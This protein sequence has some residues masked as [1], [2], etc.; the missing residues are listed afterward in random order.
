[1]KRFFG[2][3]LLSAL[4]GLAFCCAHPRTV[5]VADLHLGDPRSYLHD[6]EGLDWFVASVD[7][8]A[9]ETGGRVRELVI[10]GDA[11]ELLIADPDDAYARMADLLEALQGVRSLRRVVIVLGNHDRAVFRRVPDPAHHYNVP[12][13]G[14]TE[15]HQR[16]SPAAGRLE[17][18]LVYPA[19]EIQCHDTA[20]HITHGHYFDP[21]QTPA[22]EDVSSIAE[23]EDRNEAW[24]RAMEAGGDHEELRGLMRNAYHLGQH[25]SGLF[26]NVGALLDPDRRPTSPEID[27]QERARIAHY[28]NDVRG[29]TDDIVLVFGH[30]HTGAP[31]ATRVDPDP[32][33][34]R[35][36]VVVYN[37]G[38]WVTN[39][40]GG[41]TAT[42]VWVLDTAHGS[43]QT[44]TI[45]IP[46]E[47]DSRA[48]KR[49]Y[50]DALSPPS[51]ALP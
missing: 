44:V 42:Y 41:H 27:R 43:A 8:A 25:V 3:G 32:D 48:R 2:A 36:G 33:D 30:D 1:M 22:F 10:A 15:F 11:L 17:L 12:I 34:D 24:M 39:H 46:P 5:T 28:L 38:P 20:F 47:L 18:V 14:D 6:D 45:P 51:P 9:R 13:A 49:A 19:Y 40:K 26:A 50:E 21:W 35:P 37:L 7:E 23:I 16:L 31:A 29:R 4:A